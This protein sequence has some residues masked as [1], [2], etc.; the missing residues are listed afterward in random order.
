MLKLYGINNCD[1]VK[2]AK[3]W[4]ESN[5]LDYEFFDFKKNSLNEDILVF[6]LQNSTADQIIN[7]R[8]TS[9]RQLSD[10]E[11]SCLTELENKKSKSALTILINKPTLVK[12]PVLEFEKQIEFGFNESKYSKLLS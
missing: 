8:S 1:Q 10:S 4:L 9:W 5:N 3:V 6:W 12:R 11:K 7:K 2:K